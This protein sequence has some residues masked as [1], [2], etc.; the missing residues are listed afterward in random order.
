MIVTFLQ[1]GCGG[2]LDQSVEW[3]DAADVASSPEFGQECVCVRELEGGRKGLGCWYSFK[4]AERTEYLLYDI[5]MY[6]NV[7]VCVCVCVCEL[8]GSP[9]SVR[10]IRLG[11][12][13]A[14]GSDCGT[15]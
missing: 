4:S 7:C 11:S 14:A 9:L 10:P 6:L 2:T 12:Q 15:G 8:V 1:N 5:H 13:Q 3:P